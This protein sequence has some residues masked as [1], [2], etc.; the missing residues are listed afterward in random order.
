MV[1]YEKDEN[2][3][4]IAWGFD[5][6]LDGY[7]M[8]VT[9]NRLAWQEGSTNA[10]DEI[11]RKISIES[12]GAFFNMNSYR[13]GGFGFK[14]SEDTIFAFMRRYGINPI[15]I[16]RESLPEHTLSAFWPT[17]GTA[18][19]DRL[20]M[21]GKTPEIRLS[22]GYIKGRRSALEATIKKN[23]ENFTRLPIMLARVDRTVEE[24]AKI[25]KISILRGTA[26]AQDLSKSV[27]FFGE[28]NEKKG[29]KECAHPDCR[30][31]ER[32]DEKFR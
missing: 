28:D 29:L 24:L 3:L 7:F 2:R 25:H 1:R 11:C 6:A 17:G 30:V 32:D 10:V 15:E 14:V 27:F 19:E 9:D 31:P 12:D 26:T 23:K 13:F 20:D 8:S 22:P 18:L 21:G 16:E 4:Q 5:D